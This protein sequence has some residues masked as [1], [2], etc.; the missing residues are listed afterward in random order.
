MNADAAAAAGTCGKI[1]TDKAVDQK[2]PFRYN[3]DLQ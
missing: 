2:W 3:M 1:G